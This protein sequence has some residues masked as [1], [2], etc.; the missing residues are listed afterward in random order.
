MSGG[1][2]RRRLW[3]WRVS[4]FIGHVAQANG[5]SIA[6]ENVSRQTVLEAAIES[7]RGNSSKLAQLI[8]ENLD[9]LREIE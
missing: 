8:R 9:T 6:W 1:L 7:F 2:R 3:T 4:S 5:Y